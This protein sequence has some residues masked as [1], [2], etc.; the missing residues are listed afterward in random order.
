MFII[1]GPIYGWITNAYSLS[2]AMMVA[3]GMLIVFGG[4]ML[5]KA[6]QSGALSV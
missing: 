3:S 5:F 4:L 2:S 6:R 1:L